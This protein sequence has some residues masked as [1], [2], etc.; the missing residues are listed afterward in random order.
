MDMGSCCRRRSTAAAHPGRNDAGTARL[1]PPGTRSILRNSCLLFALTLCTTLGACSL[2]RPATAPL[3]RAVILMIGDGLGDQ[4]IT[5]ARNYQVG[6]GGRLAMDRLPVSGV[7]TTYSVQEGFPHLPEYVVDSAAS[8]TAWATGQKTSNYRLSTA[9]GSGQ[10]LPTILELAQDAGFAVGSVTTAEVTDAT[11]AALT[12][13]VNSRSCQ[14]PADMRRCATLHAETGL[15]SIA[16]QTFERRLDVLLGGG[17]GRF[18]QPLPVSAS[19]PTLIEAARLRGDQLVTGAAALT[20]ATPQQPVLGLFAAMEMSSAWR[21]L[22]ALPHPG[23]G[24][25]RCRENQRPAEQPSLAAMTMKALDLLD[26]RAAANGKGFLLQIEGACIDKL[27]HFAEPCGQLG[28]TV[29]FD[30]AVAV[31][32]DYAERHSDVLVIVTA[33]HAHTSQIVPDPWVG[34]RHPGVISTLITNE[35][36]LMTIGYATNIPGGLHNHTGSQ[37]RVAARGPGAE[38]LQGVHDQTEL[39]GIMKRALGL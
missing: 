11:P 37:V 17:R 15:G 19:A 39:F 31:V 29:E 16:E 36:A 22:P 21:G 18:E 33:D 7:I 9:A 30:A 5:A 32:L 24:P 6:A 27:D 13:H 20:A 2:H 3:A 26:Q 28:E 34:G 38:A 14:G 10:P 1:P 8:A 4:E 35:G 12:A 25:Q 23:S